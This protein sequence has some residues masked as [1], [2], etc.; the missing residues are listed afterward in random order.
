[1]RCK[2][3]V[4][5][6]TGGPEVLKFTDETVHEPGPG[7]ALVRHRAIGLNFVDIYFRS[8]IYP[9]PAM[10]FTPGTEASGIVEVV[11]RA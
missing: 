6:Q 5:S 2:A 4:V 9:A 8:G 3:I 11:G 7:E 10:P 1:V